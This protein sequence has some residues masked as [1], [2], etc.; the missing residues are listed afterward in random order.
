M[1]VQLSITEDQLVEDLVTFF[2]TLVDCEVIRGRSDGMPSPQRECI[3]ITPMVARG[4]S[5]PVSSY[6]DPS[7]ATG[8]LTMTQATQWTARVEAC[9]ARAHDLALILS[10]ALRSQYGC[11]FLERLGRMQP[12]ETGE[13]G[14]LSLD[15]AENENFERWAFDAVLQFNPSITVPQQFA[16]QLH[17]G[18]IEVDTTYPTG[19]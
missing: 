19:A 14:Q 13:L 15:G 9:G 3:V 6:A 18:L 1:G 10:I 17:V 7:P 8:T 12:L 5:L 11:E 16:D 4:L 2:T